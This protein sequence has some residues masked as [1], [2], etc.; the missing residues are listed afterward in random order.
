MD[1]GEKGVDR[2]QYVR[3][4]PHFLGR[5]GSDVRGLVTLRHGRVQLS[6]YLGTFSVVGGEGI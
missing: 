4:H 2:C 1:G 6:L 5:F 3:D